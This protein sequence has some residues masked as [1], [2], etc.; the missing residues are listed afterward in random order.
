L[1]ARNALDLSVTD[2]GHALLTL[3]RD[4]VDRVLAT[5]RDLPGQTKNAILLGPPGTGKTSAAIASAAP[6]QPVIVVTMHVEGTAVEFTGHKEIQGGN[7]VYWEGLGLEA[8]RNGALLVINEIDNASEDVLNHMYVLLDDPRVAVMHLPSGETVRP[9]PGFRVIATTN[10]RPEDIP[11]AIRDRFG[12][13]L[14]YDAPSAAMLA[15][16]DSDVATLVSE[17]YEEASQATTARERIPYV[18]FRQAAAF[19]ELRR[20][21][22]M[23]NA[24]DVARVSMQANRGVAE[25]FV[26]ELSHVGVTMMSTEPPARL[27]GRL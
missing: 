15:H 9:A 2:P 25:R 11:E 19:C 12:L 17:V 13:W 8:W 14:P 1:R 7:T 21:G 6:D 18:T 16:L 20:L 3:H 24:V 5:T 23:Q 22:V 26:S 10:G 27:L 4:D